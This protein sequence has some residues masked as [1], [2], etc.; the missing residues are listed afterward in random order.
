[1]GRDKTHSK[2]QKRHSL[3]NLTKETSKDV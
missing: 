2:R 1:M 3:Q